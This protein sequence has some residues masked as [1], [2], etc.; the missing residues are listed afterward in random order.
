MHS[1]KRHAALFRPVQP[2]PCCTAR[3]V[4][5]PDPPR[6]TRCR[7]MLKQIAIVHLTVVGL[8]PIGRA[9][10]LI[11][12]GQRTKFRDGPGHVTLLDL[13]VVE[14]ELQA[15]RFIEQGDQSLADIAADWKKGALPF[16]P[17]LIEMLDA[18]DVEMSALN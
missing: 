6:E 7:N 10:N 16:C 8:A 11:V 13:P 14:V 15:V 2:I 12:P 1:C 3:L 17:Q 9:R 5:A 4:L 18:V